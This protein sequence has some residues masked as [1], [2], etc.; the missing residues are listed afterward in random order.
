MPVDAWTALSFLLIGVA[1]TL[2]L[3][4]A[5]IALG[6][7]L[8]FLVGWART[9]GWW[10]LSWPVNLYVQ[11]IRGTPRLLIVLLALYVPPLL[12]I[13]DINLAPFFG[14]VALGISSS[15]YQAEI[16][17]SGFQAIPRGQIEAGEAIG[18]TYLQ[19]MRYVILPQTVRTIFPPLSNEFLIVLKDTSLLFTVGVVELMAQARNLQSLLLVPEP[20]FYMYLGV[21]ALYLVI[22]VSISRVMR[23]V[24][25]R[26]KVPGLGVL[27]A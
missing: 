21:A 17:R 18:L 2:W 8:G 16:F 19:S 4:A 11:L 25:G 3:T 9:S 22:T 26:F 6:V 27:S 1:N 14:V 15:A 23:F 20:I 24:E 12:G 7:G 5:S 13:I 10:W